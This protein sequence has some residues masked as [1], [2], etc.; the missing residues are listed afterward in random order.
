MGYNVKSFLYLFN[1]MILFFIGIVFRRRAEFLYVKS[2][3]RRVIVESAH[4]VSMRCGRS[5]LNKFFRRN[6]SFFNDVFPN[7]KMKFHY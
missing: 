2:I 7:G 3:K 6:K 4:S 5:V 1:L